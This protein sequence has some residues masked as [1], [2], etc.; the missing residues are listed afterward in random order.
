MPSPSFPIEGRMRCPWTQTECGYRDIR[1]IL[2]PTHSRACQG[3]E[4]QR[5]CLLGSIPG[6]GRSL[7]EGNG[8]PLQYSY[9][10]NSMDGGP[11]GLQS[12]GL[13]SRTRQ[14]TQHI[15]VVLVQ[16]H[17]TDKG[18]Y[19]QSYS[20][21]SSHVWM[22]ESDHKEGRALKNWCFQIMVL[23]MILESPLDFKEIK[24][25]NPKGNQPWMNIHW[26]DWCWNQHSNTLLIWCEEPTHWKR[27]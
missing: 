12:L 15:P 6:S 16:A 20:F 4:W 25:V 2:F 9:S 24:P 8:Y 13:Q 23:E 7:G 3:A 19:S 14:S 22:W 10:D 26:K 17:F 18:T 1:I 27:P 21:S 5:I 11:G